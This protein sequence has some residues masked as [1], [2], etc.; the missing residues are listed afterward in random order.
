M[1]PVGR[2]AARKAIAAAPGILDWG[3]QLSGKR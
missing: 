3:A 1:N 2:A